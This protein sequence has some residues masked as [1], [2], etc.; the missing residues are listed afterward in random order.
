[1]KSLVMI[2]MAVVLSACTAVS[3]NDYG[4]PVSSLELEMGR[5]LHDDDWR[6]YKNENFGPDC[7]L[8]SSRNDSDM[9]DRLM[10]Y[11]FDD[12]SKA[13]EA[14]ANMPGS[15]Y[16]ISVD[17]DDHIIGYD[18]GVCDAS[19]QSLR[20]V[21]GNVIIYAELAC[22]SGW[23]EGSDDYSPPVVDDEIADYVYA[24]HEYLAEYANEQIT[25]IIE[26]R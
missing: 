21:E 7:L 2:I 18:E 17:E 16:N 13:A 24:N 22:Y 26:S 11:I 5:S 4:R 14:F 6:V 19:I 10:F 3:G 9:K 25:A 1:M 15:M 8:L 23:S 20:Y 12:D